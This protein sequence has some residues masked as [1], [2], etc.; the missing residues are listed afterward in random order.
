[1]INPIL[2]GVLVSIYC[3]ALSH[4]A[5]SSPQPASR[6]CGPASR[7]YAPCRNRLNLP[8]GCSV[9]CGADV[10]Q[11]DASKGDI[12]ISIF[13]LATWQHRD[14]IWRGLFPDTLIDTLASKGFNFRPT[15][16]NGYARA[17]TSPLIDNIVTSVLRGTGVTGASVDRI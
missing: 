9:E 7:A 12:S 1:M 6:G 14:E 13:M 15:L 2:I 8:L 3:R 5:L 17:V 16:A 10:L 4:D 11:M